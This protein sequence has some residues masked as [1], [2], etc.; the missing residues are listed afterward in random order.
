MV[1]SYSLLLVFLAAILIFIIGAFIIKLSHLSKKIKL[2]LFLG[3]LLLV[4]LSFLGIIN[5][6]NINLNSFEG[7]TQA[8]SIYLE[9]ITNSFKSLNSIGSNSIKFVGNVIKGNFTI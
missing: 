7:Y 4:Y 5:N 8:V 1:I 6:N 3:I 9:S 2:F